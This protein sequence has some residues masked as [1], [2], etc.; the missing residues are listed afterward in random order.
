M[1]NDVV[2]YEKVYQ[3][4]KNKILSG[5][6][7]KGSKLPSRANLCHEFHTSEKTVRRA[8]SMLIEEGFV[9][10]EQRKRPVVAY[11]YPGEKPPDSRFL[12]RTEAD[13]INDLL[14]TG[15]L[16]CYPINERGMYL[17]IG[18]DW[19]IPEAIVEKMDPEQ[20]TEF[21]GLS[22]RFWHFFICRNEND[23]IVR[24][25]DSLGFQEM[26]LLP[27]TLELRKKYRTS[28]KELI[29][30]MKHGGNPERV[31]F[32]DLFVLYGF[33]SEDGRGTPAYHMAIKSA[34]KIEAQGLEYQLSRAQEL[35]SGVYLDVIGLVAMGQY[36]QGDRLPSYQDMSEYYG[37]SIDTISK[38]LSI[39]QQWGVVTATRGRGTFVA[40]DQDA[41]KKIQIDPDLIAGHVRRFA[42]SMELL[43]MTIEGIAAHTAAYVPEEEARWLADELNRCWEDR[44]LYQR[45]PSVLLDF[46][47]KHIPYDVLRA[48]Y[49]V[50][51]RNY[52]IG[53]SIPKLIDRKKTPEDYE[54][55]QM[56]LETSGFL[57]EGDCSGYAK[58]MKE[59]FDYTQELAVSSCKSLGY[60]EAAMKVY[61][62]TMLWK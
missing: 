61:D 41:L 51:R 12:R 48:V 19:N 31:H 54:L 33:S 4:L 13:A 37:V 21:W 25:V 26:E 5:L 20:P 43:S 58:S 44:Y 7:V 62:G 18:D 47:I 32:D 23:L 1:K 27:G 29:Q 14:K 35:Y 11:E 38:A 56:S 9:E 16:L 55:F 36:K 17:C 10:T 24:T 60:W 59:V 3:I 15:V 49:G 6:L 28:L 30:T 34:L 39:L 50:V 42:D 52:R 22:N 45:S 40:M 57:I 53:R 2:M 8:L 46:L